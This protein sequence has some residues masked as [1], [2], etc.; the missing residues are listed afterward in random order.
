MNPLFVSILG[1]FIR[2]AL[3]LGAGWLVE[4]QVWAQ[5]EAGGYVSGL[6]L[7]LI[8]LLWAVWTRYKSRVKFLTALEAPAGATEAHVIEKIADGKGAAVI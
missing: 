8:T 6:T 2:W 5:D 7:A 4:H 1:S 3:T